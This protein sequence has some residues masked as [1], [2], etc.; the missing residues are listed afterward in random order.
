MKNNAAAGSADYG[1]WYDL[2]THPQ[3][4]SATLSVCPQGIPLGKFEGN[5]AHTNGRYG[6]HIF[7]TYVPRTDPC[8]PESISDV[9]ELDHNANPP[10]TA[11]FSDFTSYKNLR[12]GFEGGILG[13]VRLVDFRLAD[14]ARAGIEVELVTAPRGTIRSENCTIVGH[15]AN[16]LDPITPANVVGEVGIFGFIA[17]R[18][19]GTFS[20]FCLIF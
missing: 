12:D 14:N 10:I 18:K 19:V 15:S 7:Q 8:S 9:N 11:T 2:R 13:D 17:P 6:L 4:P 20:V 5:R 3:G 16:Q 1:F